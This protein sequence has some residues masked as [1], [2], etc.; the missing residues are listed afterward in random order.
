MRELASVR[1]RD[2][3]VGQRQNRAARGGGLEARLPLFFIHRPR[4]GFFKRRETRD[5]G[6]EIGQADVVVN[7]EVHRA[8]DVAER[9]RRLIENAEVDDLQVVERRHDHIGDDDGD[10]GVELAEGDKKRA[11]MDDAPDGADDVAEHVPRAIDLPLLALEQRDLFAV[12]AD[13]R[14]VET[15]V[16]L[17]RL[18]AEIEPRKILPDELNDDRGDAGIEDGD[19]EQ[20]AW[21]HDAEDRGVH[22]PRNS[23]EDDRERHEVGGRG[24]RLD[25]VVVDADVAR[26][27]AGPA[28]VDESANVL[29]DTLIRVVAGVAAEVARPVAVVEVAGVERQLVVHRPEEPAR[30]ERR[31]HPSSPLQHEI[32]SDKELED[33]GGNGDHRE[34]HEDEHQLIP[35]RDAMRFVRDLDRVAE[36]PLEEVETQGKRDLKL[37]DEDE[38]E[39]IDA[40]IEVLPDD[41]RPKRQRADRDRRPR[42]EE[43]V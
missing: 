26:I 36:I 1:Q 30:G 38:K 24:D 20:K 25:R 17:D 12:F 8:V 16:R 33:A 27:D 40:R 7:E 37:I 2:V 21:D 35:E 39:D 15:E 5:C 28:A 19:P 31:R 10:L 43:R 41:D 18:L 6:P 13:A 4:E 22:G 42:G 14:Q 29:R 9:V 3:D 34:R 23:P 11:H 32:G